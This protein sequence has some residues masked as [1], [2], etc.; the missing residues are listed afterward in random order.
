MPVFFRETVMDR[1]AK[2]KPQAWIDSAL[3]CSAPALVFGILI[4]FCVSLYLQVTATYPEKAPI[5]IHSHAI[6]ASDLP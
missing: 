6:D 2:T 1:H 4:V 5:P 3:I